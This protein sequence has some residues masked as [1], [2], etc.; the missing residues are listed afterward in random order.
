MGKNKWSC[1]FKDIHTFTKIESKHES[2]KS[3]MM[4]GLDR[5]SNPESQNI[6][7]RHTI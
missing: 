4:A 2:K 7:V 1:S 6:G 5:N 3:A